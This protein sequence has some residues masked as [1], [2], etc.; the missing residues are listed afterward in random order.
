MSNPKI[1]ICQISN[2]KINPSTPVEI[3][4]N[5]PL[6]ENERKNN[7]FHN[8]HGLGTERFSAILLSQYKFLMKEFLI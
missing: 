8:L 2:P 3:F 4:S 6:G 5:T 7:K 1:T